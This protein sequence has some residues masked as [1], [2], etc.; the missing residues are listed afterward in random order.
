MNRALAA[1]TSKLVGAANALLLLLGTACA[2][3][4]SDADSGRNLRGGFP[5]V[6]Q[7][8]PVMAQA[9][10][11]AAGSIALGDF[12][13]PTSVL[14]MPVGGTGAGGNCHQ[15]TVAFVIDGSGSMCEKF[16]NSTR[17]GELRNA[18]LQANTGLLYKINTF[19]TVGAYI[20]DGTTDPSLLGMG[21]TVGGGMGCGFVRRPPAQ[22]TGT[23]PQLVEIKPKPM[24]AAAIDLMYPTIELGGSTPTDKAMNYVVDQLIALGRP[25]QPLYGNPQFIILATDGQPNDICIGGTGGDGTAQQRGVIAAVD[26]ATATGIITYVV[27]LASDPALQAH[28]DEV[29][30]H[31][32]PKDPMAHT[33]T[34]TNSADLVMTLGTILNTA[35]GCIF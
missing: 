22:G 32:N 24:N 30:R 5:P 13:S 1:D 2:G 26:K 6:T 25:G 8:M 27:S 16:G 29:A 3:A 7:P 4:N 28:L 10:M 31:G 15:A 17:W 9:P 19:A 12:G 11:T 20:Y 33:F 23:C 18:L 34:P 21:A 14:P 35:V